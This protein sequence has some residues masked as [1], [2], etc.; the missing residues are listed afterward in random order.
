MVMEFPNTISSEDSAATVRTSELE[1]S[2]QSR[3]AGRVSNFCL[4][5][6]EGGIILRGVSRTYYAKQLAQHAVMQVTELP[7]IANEIKVDC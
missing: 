4:V 5:R 2:V 3:L 6:A 1:L 7:I